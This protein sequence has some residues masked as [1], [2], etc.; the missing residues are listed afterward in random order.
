MII[1][2]EVVLRY[3]FNT[4]L[5]WAPEIAGFCMVWMVYMGAALGVKERFHIRVFVGVMALAPKPRL[6]FVLLA[7]LV[8][9]VFNLVMIWYSI[10]FLQSAYKYP[11]LSPD[12]RIN[13]F[14]PQTIVLIG[15]VLI[16]VRLIQIYY[17]WVRRGAKGIPGLPDEYRS[18][19]HKTEGA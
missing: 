12:L 17:N 11:N 18:I 1:V 13:L 5:S 4:G 19:E 3:A 2:V 16:T 14:W 9:L 7:D 15:Y 8:W 6:F 10:P